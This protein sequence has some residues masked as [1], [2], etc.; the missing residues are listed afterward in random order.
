VSIDPND[1]DIY[2]YITWGD[3]TIDEWIGPYS[4]GEKIYL[5][6]SWSEKGTYEI[7]ARAKN[8]VDQRGEIGDL[9]VSMTRTRLQ[10]STLFSRLLEN[11]PLLKEMLSR[12]I[13]S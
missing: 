12:L 6:H 2:Y 13:T 3:G 7:R 8:T 10:T 11:F 9:K 1:E 5:N 4:S